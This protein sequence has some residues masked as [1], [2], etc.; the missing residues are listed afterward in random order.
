MGWG[1]VLGGGGS[2]EGVCGGGGG[3]G[4]SVR[5]SLVYEVE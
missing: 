3:G 5:G 1:G 2:M 4:R